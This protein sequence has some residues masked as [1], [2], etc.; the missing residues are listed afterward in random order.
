MNPRAQELIANTF[1]THGKLAGYDT[2]L[3]PNNTPCAKRRM[4]KNVTNSSLS[5]AVSHHEGHSPILA[6]LWG[7]LSG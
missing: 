5:S 3:N 4:S 7:G 2:C 1:R 6:G